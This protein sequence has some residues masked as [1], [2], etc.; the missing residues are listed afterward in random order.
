LHFGQAEWFW[1]W[2][3]LIKLKSTN[4]QAGGIGDEYYLV[5]KKK[6]TKLVAIIIDKFYPIT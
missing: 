5:D 1:D 6:V 2:N 3:N 4:W